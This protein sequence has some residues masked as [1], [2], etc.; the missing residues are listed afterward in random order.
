MFTS[1]ECRAMALSCLKS[2]EAP[3]NKKDQADWKAMSKEWDILA[4]RADAHNAI[5]QKLRVELPDKD[6]PLFPK[7]RP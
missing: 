1:A 3:E 6:V 5:L 7:Q 4:A 2:S